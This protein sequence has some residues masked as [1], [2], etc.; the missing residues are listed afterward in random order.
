LIEWI[1][2]G[3]SAALVFY[4]VIMACPVRDILLQYHW[5]VDVVFTA[6]MMLLLAG[7]YSGAMTAAVGGLILTGL[8]W[9]SAWWLVPITDE[10][11]YRGKP[12]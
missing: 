12:E 4:V 8:L 5:L 11:Y 9:I 6:C 2:P 3:I 10:E 7:T 1:F